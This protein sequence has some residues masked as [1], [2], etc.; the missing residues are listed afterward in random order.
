[1]SSLK[2]RIQSSLAQIDVARARLAKT[3]LRAPLDGFVTRQD[4]E[5]GEILQPNDPVLSVTSESQYEIEAFVPEVDIA[6]VSLGYAAELSLDAYGP[7]EVF[8]A[9]VVAIDPAE[10]TIEGVSTYKVILHFS[11]ADERIRP[12]L[13]ANVD[14]ISAVRASALAVP[15]RAVN[16]RN[17]HSS[18]QMLEQGAMIERAVQTGIVS[19]DGYVEILSGLAEGESIVTFI[20]S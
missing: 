4:A 14:I 12:G 1:M 15:Q 19:W 2:A 6:Q 13:T 17:G 11:G 20:N 10:T 18:V 5:V 3:V 8:L 16:R 7:D 9:E